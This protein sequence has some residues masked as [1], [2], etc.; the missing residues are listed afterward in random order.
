MKIAILSDIH[1]NYTALKSVFKEAKNL[2]V[3]K[4]LFLGDFTGYYYETKSVL[5]SIRKL[6]HVMIKGNHEL[7]LKDIINN[8]I[9]IKKITK[10]YGSGMEY[11]L[12]H[13]NNDEINYLIKLPSRKEIVLDETKILIAH[14]S[15]WDIKNYIYPDSSLK[16]KQRC[17]NG[18][19]DFVFIGHSHYSFVYEYKDKVLINVG[20]IGQN[21]KHGGIATWCFLDTDK[22]Y[23]EIKKTKYDIYELLNQ[24][25]RNDP[26]NKYLK[27]VLL[28]N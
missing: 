6:D 7:L 28:R 2:N 26:N 8:K 21:R 23:Y 13:L 25:E 9:N 27:N 14:G 22:N 17:L 11:A 20:S 19:F 16:D 4:Y 5:E 12:K 3:D 24:I 15:P 18:D 1:G 10:K